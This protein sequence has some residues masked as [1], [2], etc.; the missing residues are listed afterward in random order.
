[1]CERKRLDC[2]GFLLQRRLRIPERAGKGYRI[3]LVFRRLSAGAG[4]AEGMGRD[5]LGVV[6]PTGREDCG[7]ASGAGSPCGSWSS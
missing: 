2:K 7:W 5:R 4:C 1:M 3:F 6:S